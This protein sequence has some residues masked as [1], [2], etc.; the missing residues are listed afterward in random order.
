M[1]DFILDFADGTVPLATGDCSCDP[2][3][4]DLL[5]QLPRQYAEEIKQM[6]ELMLKYGPRS[7]IELRRQLTG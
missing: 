7:I 4:L 6:L 5:K 1:S 3:I 2:E